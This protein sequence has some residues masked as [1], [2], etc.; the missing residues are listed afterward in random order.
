MKIGSTSNNNASFG[1]FRVVMGSDK[2]ERETFGMLFKEIKKVYPE[3][4]IKHDQSHQAIGFIRKTLYTIFNITGK[5]EKEENQ[6]AASFATAGFQVLKAI[7]KPVER[8]KDGI[9]A[10]MNPVKLVAN[11]TKKLDV[12]A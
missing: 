10:L 6:A 3:T 11:N 9:A 4:Q 12:A 7:R 2:G 5:N 1:S 8:V